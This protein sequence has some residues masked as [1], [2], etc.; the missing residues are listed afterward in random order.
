MMIAPD[1]PAIIAKSS[2]SA[3]RAVSQEIVA[4]I[5]KATS[6]AAAK[7]TT[8]GGMSSAIVLRGIKNLRA[9]KRSKKMTLSQ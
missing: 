3:N 7:E 5:A 9:F 6:A 2:P 1:P 8:A 4:K